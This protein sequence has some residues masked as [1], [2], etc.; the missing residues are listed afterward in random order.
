MAEYDNEFERL[1]EAASKVKADVERLVEGFHL[2]ILIK[3]VEDFGRANPMG[4]AVTA[5][6]LGVAAG[7]LVNTT[8]RNYIH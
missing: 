3:K 4:L 6:T 7:I 1:N 5:L 2:E 8:K